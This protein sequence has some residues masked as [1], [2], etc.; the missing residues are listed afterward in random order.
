[1]SIAIIANPQAGRGR[2]KKIT[3]QV[4]TILNKK[5][6]DYQLFLTKMPKEA[7]ELSYRA[8][9]NHSKI[10]ALGGDGTINEV[11]T[12][13][14]ESK[15]QLG[16]I[17]GG[18]GNDYVRGLGLSKDPI[19]ALEIVLNGTPTLI[20]VAKERDRIFGVVSTLGFP[21]TVLKYVNSHSDSRISGPPVFLAAVAKTI[22]NLHSYQVQVTVDDY[23]IETDMVGIIMM[24]MPYG[25]GGLKFAPDAH[26]SD[27]KISVVIIKELSKFSLLK[28]LPKVYSGRH[29][30]HPKVE[31]V[32]GKTVSITAD[33]SLAKSF[34]G[35]VLG[36]TPYQA[37]IEPKAVSVIVKP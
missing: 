14:W 34:D 25:G 15:A 10:V 18:T 8:A 4:K 37:V 33:V 28:A 22:H 17:P 32:T 26:Y 2:G 30:S 9:A 11:L 3:E 29:V 27:G 24:N 36:E 6:V 35:E 20:D 5:N 31:I 1:M 13:M 12:G 21:S 19:T 23:H 16:I 7:I